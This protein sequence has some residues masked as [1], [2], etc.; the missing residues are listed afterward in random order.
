MRLLLTNDDGIDADGTRELASFLSSRGH[1]VTVVAPF[2][3]Q[4]GSSAALGITQR[5][6]VRW[7]DR[8]TPVAFGGAHCIAIDATPAAAVML[9][10]AGSVCP[11]PQA[12][13]AGINH[14]LNVGRAILH[15]GTVGAVLTAA[16]LGISAAAISMDDD[17]PPM[18]ST[19]VRIAEATLE[20]LGRAQSRTVVNV[21]VPALPM[22]KLRG[23]RRGVIAAYGRDRPVLDP[24]GG[25]ALAVG[26]RPSP[27]P[28]DP[29]SDAG[30]VSNGFVSVSGL[31]G[32]QLSG[33]DLCAD[34]AGLLA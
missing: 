3:N 22:D 30:L 31:V 21:N 9:G 34:I 8:G 1:E 19:A 20:A 5:T 11:R 15:S 27:V 24:A 18:W 16:S 23:Y 25:G 13:V 7:E 14:G 28:L 2:D 12:V 26:R 4:S 10:C 32:I 6:A 17:A 33:V 29:D